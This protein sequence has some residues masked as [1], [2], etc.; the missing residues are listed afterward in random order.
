M[1]ATWV[2]AAAPRPTTALLYTP[3]RVFIDRKAAT[4]HCEDGH[5]ACR[6]KGNCDAVTL[7]EDDALHC[8]AFRFMFMDQLREPVVNRDKA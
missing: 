6:A 8:R 1:K 4:R 5:F 2:F 3:R 7:D